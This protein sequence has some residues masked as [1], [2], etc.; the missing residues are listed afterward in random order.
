MHQGALTIAR[1][2][3]GNRLPCTLTHANCGTVNHRAA[4]MQKA[5]CPG[6]I[7]KPKGAPRRLAYSVAHVDKLCYECPANK[8][9]AL[10][11]CKQGTSNGYVVPILH[12]SVAPQSTRMP[13]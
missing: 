6:A 11:L 7:C 5:L 13:A 3:K 4:N 1:R 10:M 2:S 8:Q 12:Y 9:I